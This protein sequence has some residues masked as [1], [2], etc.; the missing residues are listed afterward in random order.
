[1]TLQY[2]TSVRNSQLDAFET[3]TGGTAIMKIYQ[4]TAA[5]PANCGAAITGTVLATLTLPADWMSAANAG[6][7]ALSG[8]WSDTSADAAGTASW[9]R[10][11]K[12]DGTTCQAQGTVDQGSGDISLDN[13]VIAAAQTVTISTFTLTAGNA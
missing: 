2:A 10:I 12:N 6:T 9:F 1:M 3:D 4:L 13:K 8:T 5:A 7:K 11:F